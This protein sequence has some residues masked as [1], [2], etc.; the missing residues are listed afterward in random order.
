[1]S[2]DPDG[3]RLTRF[4]DNPRTYRIVRQIPA[5][6]HTPLIGPTAIICRSSLRVP[7]HRKQV[8]CHTKGVV[9]PSLTETQRNYHARG[10]KCAPK[11]RYFKLEV[12]CH[13]RWR[14]H[15]RYGRRHGVRKAGPQRHRFRRCSSNWRGTT[16]LRTF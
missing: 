5:L 13:C 8:I 7:R 14:R 12:E 6:P 16:A 3:D 10:N 15:R 1:M 4:P 11:H 2:Q 9:Q